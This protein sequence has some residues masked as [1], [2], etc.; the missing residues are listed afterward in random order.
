MVLSLQA[1]PEHTARDNGAPACV[2][3]NVDATNWC[4]VGNVQPCCRR[5]RENDST[6]GGYGVGSPAGR[7]ACTAAGC[8]AS[9]TA[10]PGSKPIIKTASS[11]VVNAGIER[12]LTRAMIAAGGALC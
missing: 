2:V 7:A 10:V 6:H 11:T 12:T 5:I 3:S 9:P 8:A 4:R 1:T